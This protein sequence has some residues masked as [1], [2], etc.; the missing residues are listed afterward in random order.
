MSSHNNKGLSQASGGLPESP[1]G[2]P[3]GPIRPPLGQADPAACR[4]VGAARA[5][6]GQSRA[7]REP[8]GLGL[9][10][11]RQQKAQL[12]GSPDSSR[13]PCARKWRRKKRERH[14]PRE[15]YKKL[16]AHVASF[17]SKLRGDP[18]LQP[19]IKGDLRGFRADLQALIRGQFALRRGP[20]TDPLIDEACRLVIEKGRTVPEALR[21][22]IKNWKQLDPYTR[23]LASRG[24]HQA[25]NR[26]LR[27]SQGP[28][29][30]RKA[31]Q[32]S[33]DKTGGKKSALTRAE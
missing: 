5:D 13:A 16:S 2:N 15:I 19:A 10:G 23:S 24:L 6:P 4:D 32:Q 27:A 7:K 14:L 12:E 1:F 21:C 33:S 22:Q 8:G 31:E 11:S 17:T 20:H 26:R 3:G 28:R 29:K 25:V 30:T 18:E 9:E